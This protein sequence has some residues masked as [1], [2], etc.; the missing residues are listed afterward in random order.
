MWVRL[1]QWPHQF[2]RC[3]ECG[4]TDVPLVANRGTF[5]C[6]HCA[7]AIAAAIAAPVGEQLGRLDA[8]L[9]GLDA[10]R[11]QLLEQ[12]ALLAPRRAA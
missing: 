12:R 4:G 10:H 6:V 7:T 9:A 11:E 8:E 2:A 3:D 1:D 5:L